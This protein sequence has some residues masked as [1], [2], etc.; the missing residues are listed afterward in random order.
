MT[1]TYHGDNMFLDKGRQ[2]N[3][4]EEESKVELCSR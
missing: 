2:R 4:P 1:A 3:Q